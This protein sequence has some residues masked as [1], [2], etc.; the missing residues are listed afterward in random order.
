MIGRVLLGIILH[1]FGPLRLNNMKKDPLDFSLVCSDSLNMNYTEFYFI[2]L[3]KL[4]IERPFL[5]TN[6]SFLKFVKHMSLDSY[7]GWD[8]S[9]VFYPLWT[10]KNEKEALINHDGGIKG[11]ESFCKSNGSCLSPL[12]MALVCISFSQLGIQLTYK[13]IHFHESCH[14]FESF[15]RMHCP[16]SYCVSIWSSRAVKSFV[17]PPNV[18]RKKEVH[19]YS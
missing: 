8:I 19:P 17:M 13:S 16:L 12:K 3:V 9:S 10:R 15:K 6:P 11:R 14:S 7:E 2:G 18:Q 1:F 4:N 5:G